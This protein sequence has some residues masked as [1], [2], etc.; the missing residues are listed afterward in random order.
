MFCWGPGGLSD[1]ETN[2]SFEEDDSLGGPS[3]HAELASYRDVRV[4]LCLSTDL[5]VLVMAWY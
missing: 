4:Y 1:D 5:L 3:P 2:P